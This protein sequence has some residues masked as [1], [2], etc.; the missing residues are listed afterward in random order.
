MTIIG[1]VNFDKLIK[2]IERFPGKTAEFQDEFLT[3]QVRLL[4]SNPRGTTP[5]ILQ[6]T[7]PSSAGV[8]GEESKLQGEKRIMSDFSK[9]YKFP[10]HVYGL[11][12]EHG[13]DNMAAV[14]WKAYVAGDI[15]KMMSIVSRVEG[16]PAW[17]SYT[18]REFDAGAAI[19][20]RRSKSTGRAN[21]SKP[22]MLCNDPAGLI[23]YRKIRLGRVG[24]LASIIPTAAISVLT[25]IKGI[26]KFVKRH[27]GAWGGSVIPIKRAKGKMFKIGIG[28]YAGNEMQRRMNYALEY[29]IKNIGRQS[30]AIMAKK[31]EEKFQKEINSATRNP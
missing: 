21:G 9:V 6:I 12:R 30:K 10:R 25:N 18:P 31:L 8:K 28:A 27:K 16:L 1:K 15:K 23:A 22:S 2:A 13:N 29:R 4:I 5:G 11:I 26:P 14:Y 17:A 3:Q 24:L 7:P 20:A 19:K